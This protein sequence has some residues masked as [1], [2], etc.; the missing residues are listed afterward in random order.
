MRKRKENDLLKS[1][2]LGHHPVSPWRR[3]RAS[4]GRP[5]VR[6]SYLCAKP[7]RNGLYPPR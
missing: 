1:A 7:E 5:Y 4:Q 3:E 6:P 2:E